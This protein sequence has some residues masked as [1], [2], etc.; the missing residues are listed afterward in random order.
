M[1]PGGGVIRAVWFAL[2]AVYRTL[3]IWLFVVKMGLGY[4]WT[5]WGLMAGEAETEKKMARV[6]HS[7][8]VW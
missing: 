5:R 6:R 7:G 1:K 4:C 3:H 2:F 8:C